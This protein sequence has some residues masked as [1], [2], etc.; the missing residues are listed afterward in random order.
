MEVI[1]ISKN[2]FQQLFEDSQCKLGE[3]WQLVS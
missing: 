2:A 1:Y 3:Y